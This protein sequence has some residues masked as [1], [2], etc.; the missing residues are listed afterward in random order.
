MKTSLP[1]FKNFPA[2]SIDSKATPVCL[3]ISFALLDSSLFGNITTICL[4]FFSSLWGNLA[5]GGS[6]LQ[7][8]FKNVGIPIN[9]NPLSQAKPAATI[10]QQ[11]LN[12]PLQICRGSIY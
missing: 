3:I 7:L 4:I 8:A 12:A 10:F 6:K 9:R 11:G 5:F 2:G 1:T